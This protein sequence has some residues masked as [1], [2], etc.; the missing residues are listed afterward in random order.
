MNGRGE[1]GR[2][3]NRSAWVNLKHVSFTAYEFIY[4]ETVL[5]S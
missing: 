1:E 5:A 4:W 3:E 2:K